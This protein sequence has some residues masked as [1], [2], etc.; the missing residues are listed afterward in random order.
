M[1]MLKVKSPCAE[2]IHLHSHERGQECTI[3]TVC[4]DESLH[5]KMHHVFLPMNLGKK[6]NTIFIFHPRVSESAVWQNL[7]L[8][9]GCV[10]FSGLYC[11]F[12]TPP[13]IGFPIM[14]QTNSPSIRIPGFLLLG[15]LWFCNKATR[16]VMEWPW[17]SAILKTERAQNW[18]RR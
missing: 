13:T 12:P 18:M 10:G 17:P 15:I 1:C 8:R 5:M 16:G 14:L 4:R 2:R 6:F 11:L 7:S 3:V 9:I